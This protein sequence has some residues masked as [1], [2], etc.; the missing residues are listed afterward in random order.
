MAYL[1]NTKHNTLTK[2]HGLYA[3]V[4]VTTIRLC[5][6]HTPAQPLSQHITTTGTRTIVR[7]HALVHHIGYNTYS[8]TVC[9]RRTALWGDYAGMLHSP[10]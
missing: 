9:A 5:Y 3:L 6:S 4:Q 8:T 10:H 7:E 1:L 2:W